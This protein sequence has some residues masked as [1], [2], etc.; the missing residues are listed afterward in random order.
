VTPKQF[1]KFRQR[2]FDR[3]PHCGEDES[4]VP[5]H[6]LNRGMGGSKERDKP[7]N[8]LTFCARANDLMESSAWFAMEARDMGWKLESGQI[9][10]ET[11][12]F[13]AC[14]GFWYLLDDEFNRIRQG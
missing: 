1:L 3:C 12:F 2:D 13:D 10:A 8:I 4:L 14:D 11:A 9:P 6:R 5:H 7:S